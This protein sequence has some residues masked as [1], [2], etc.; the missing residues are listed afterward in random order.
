MRVVK[1]EDIRMVDVSEKADVVRIARA[2]GRIHL[3]KSTIKGIVKGEV[4]KGDPLS[5]AKIA[6]ILAAKKVPSLIPLC[7]P[8]PITNVSVNYEVTENDI[9]VTSEVKGV[10]KTG[11]EME[12]LTAAAV[13]LL[14]VWDMVKGY[15]KDEKGQYPVTRIDEIMVVEKVREPLE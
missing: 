1:G 10:G 7:H 12:A 11:V 14:T 6:A 13:A 2:M 8:V 3:R 9:I 5:T 15:E 4:E